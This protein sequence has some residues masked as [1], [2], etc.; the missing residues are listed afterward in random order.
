[1]GNQ[2][3]GITQQCTETL[4]LLIYTNDI[5]DLEEHMTEILADHQ[6]VLS[7]GEDHE[8]TAKNYRFQ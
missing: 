5:S 7:I 8:K 6:A 3:D 4:T 2:G 1:M